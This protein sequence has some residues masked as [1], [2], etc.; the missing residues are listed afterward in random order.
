MLKINVTAVG[1]IKD[2]YIKD[3]ILEFKKRLQK[4]SNFSIIELKEE[5][6][7]RGIVSAVNTE[8]KRILEYIEGKNYYNILLDLDG[9]DV[10]STVMAQKIMEISNFN[11]KINFIIG[12]SNGVNN[13]VKNTADFRLSFSKLT[14]P[15]QLIRIFLLEQI[16]RAFKISNNET[17]H[18]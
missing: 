3:G 4:F 1:K 15:H 17:Y 13:D 12:G 18:R 2:S 5:S 6:E 14:F 8:S 16:F 10:S 11:S 7:N 9:I